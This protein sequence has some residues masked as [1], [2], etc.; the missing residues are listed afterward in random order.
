MCLGRSTA[1]FG[2]NLGDMIYPETGDL[3]K[4]PSAQASRTAKP[5]KLKTCT[6]GEAGKGLEVAPKFKR[7]A[8]VDVLV[9]KGKAGK[10]VEL[11]IDAQKA[12]GACW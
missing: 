5:I 10:D 1:S 3:C 2:L 8:S 9:L 4:S 12:N 11:P 6:V 7:A